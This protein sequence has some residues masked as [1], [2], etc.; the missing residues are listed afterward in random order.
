MTKAKNQIPE[1]KLKLHDKLINTIPAIER[2]RV[3]M[4][5]TS[6]NGHMFTYLSKDGIMGLRLP[7]DEREA[8]L[9]S[10]KLLYLN[11]TEQL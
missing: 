1:D 11:S 3:N 7:K 8:F 2:K 4:P 6:V 5:Y 10:I 9:K